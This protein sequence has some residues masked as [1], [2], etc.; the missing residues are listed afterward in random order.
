MNRFIYNKVFNYFDSHRYAKEWSTAR[1][2]Q[3][4][5]MLREEDFYKMCRI[6][7][8]LRSQG[9]VDGQMAKDN[10]RLVYRR[11]VYK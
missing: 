9:Y 6:I 2:I 8:I 3:D 10:S 1:E 5:L 11:K 7:T 4:V